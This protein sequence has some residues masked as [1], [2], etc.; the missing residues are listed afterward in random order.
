MAGRSNASGMTT[1]APG[2]FITSARLTHIVADASKASGGLG[3]APVAQEL[4]LI[5]LITCALAVIDGTAR[6][7]SIPAQV[8][9]E[10]ENE[11]DRDDTTRYRAAAMIFHFQ[12]AT[13]CQAESLVAAFTAV[14]PIYNTLA[15]TTPVAITVTAEE[16]QPAVANPGC[17]AA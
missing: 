2:R 13:Q 7:R 9:I 16:P 1:G 8:R 4:Y 14:C 15:R 12:G 5:S 3:E 11:I 17:P 10:A 6:D